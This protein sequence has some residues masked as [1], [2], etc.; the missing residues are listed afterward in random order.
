MELQ[1]EINSQVSSSWIAANNPWYR[2]VWTE[3]AEMMDHVGWK[4]WKMQESDIL[5]VRLEVVDIWHF[6]LSDLI[7]HDINPSEVEKLLHDLWSQSEPE[8]DILELIE[9]FAL[10]TLQKKRFSLDGFVKLSKAVDLDL[11]ALFKLYIGKNALNRFR[12]DHGYKQG[13]YIKIWKSREDNEWLMDIVN[14][15]D[16]T[17]DDILKVIYSLLKEKY[18]TLNGLHFR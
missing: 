7:Q 13:T 14:A 3:C 8:F 1:R 17:Q 12:Q 11:D 6:G 18:F 9:D 10:N 2:A 15:I 5:Q 16:S 4:W